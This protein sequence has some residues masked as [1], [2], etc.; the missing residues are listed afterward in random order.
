MPV[1]ASVSMINDFVGLQGADIRYQ[2]TDDGM[3][4]HYC[5]SIA[6][7]GYAGLLHGGMAATLI[8]DV[9]VNCLLARKIRAMTADLSLRYLSPVPIATPLTVNVTIAKQRQR[10]YCLQ[11]RLLVNDH[12]AVRAKAKFMAQTP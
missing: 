1:V 9:M 5:P 11:A 8:D 2:L 10:M 3:I 6:W 12:V 7:Q 4:G